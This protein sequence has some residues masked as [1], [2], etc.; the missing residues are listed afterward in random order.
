[1]EVEATS[2]DSTKME[3]VKE[4]IEKKEREPTYGDVVLPL[5]KEHPELLL[6]HSD[7]YFDRPC[8]DNKGGDISKDHAVNEW[9]FNHL[10]LSTEQKKD[11]LA[12]LI[13]DQRILEK[14]MKAAETDKKPLKKKK[15]PKKQKRVGPKSH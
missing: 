2:L 12:Q 1:M 3:D 5:I 15:L 8:P 14:K 4:T 13:A 6:G 10:P 7:P 11:L 9:V